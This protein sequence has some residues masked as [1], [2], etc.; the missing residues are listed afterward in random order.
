MCSAVSRSKVLHFIRHGQAAHNP[1][2]EKAR[3]GG[4]DFETFLRLMK[5]DDAFD[6][7]LTELGVKQAK[8]A[9]AAFKQQAQ[10]EQFQRKASGNDGSRRTDLNQ[11]ELLVVSPLSRAIDTGR[12]VLC[13][14]SSSSGSGGDDSDC[15]IRP[16]ATIVRFAL[17]D[18]DVACLP[19]AHFFAF[20]HNPLSFSSCFI[21]SPHSFA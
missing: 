3:H 13:G 14:S 18:N 20:R 11:V 8:D 9:H 17:N 1:R 15:L 10:Q 5:E 21:T 2:A 7:P 12:M 4:C 6:S 19:P 16:D